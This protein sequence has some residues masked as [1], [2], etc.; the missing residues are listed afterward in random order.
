[1]EELIINNS[2]L[3]TH[4]L[5]RDCPSTLMGIANRDYPRK[6]YFDTLN[7]D[8]LD[9]DTYEKN[10][11]KGHCGN[12]A[13]T[14][15]AVIGIA[16]GKSGD[17]LVH[18]AVMIVE[19]RMGYKHGDN[20]SLRD[21]KRKVTHT[22]TLLAVTLPIHAN[23]YFVFTDNEEPQAK[24]LLYREA[25]EIGSMQDYK[26][27]SVSEFTNCMKDPSQIPY[28]YQYSDEN[29]AQSFNRCLTNKICDINNF[30][31]QFYYWLGII[32]RMKAH[33]NQQEAK[34]ITECLNKVLEQIKQIPLSEE[35][36]M[37]VEILSEELSNNGV[38]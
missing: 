31:K 27:A 9:L 7:V 3:R 38:I 36:I 24:S 19:L 16:L 26:I 32:G 12:L 20:I 34:H 11:H 21:L 18:P 35:D 13:C 25:Q 37:E 28:Q 23:Y 30:N 6:N 5:W 8:A 15:D 4:P 14:G 29:I 17:T 1:M 22:K 2:Y 33:Y 10:I